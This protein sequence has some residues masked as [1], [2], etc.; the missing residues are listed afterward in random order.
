MHEVASLAKYDEET[1]EAQCRTVRKI[2]EIAN[3]P[4]GTSAIVEANILEHVPHLLGLNNAETRRYL[5]LI[6]GKL[7]L[8][9]RHSIDQL[10]S[11]LRVR[12]CMRLKRGERRGVGVLMNRGNKMSKTTNNNTNSDENIDVREPARYAIEKI[13]ENLDK[14]PGLSKPTATCEDCYDLLATSDPGIRRFACNVLGN[15]AVHYSP[16]DFVGLGHTHKLSLP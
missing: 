5:Q 14:T 6:L 12:V 2:S 10:G 7:L 4:D 1:M 11:P 3:C 15:I 13:A 16:L 9:K 8:H